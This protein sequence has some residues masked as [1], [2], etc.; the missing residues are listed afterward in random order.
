MGKW[1]A[2][3]QATAHNQTPSRAVPRNT[4]D[5]EAPDGALTQAAGARGWGGLVL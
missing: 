1:N 2:Q 5:R 3:S 4:N